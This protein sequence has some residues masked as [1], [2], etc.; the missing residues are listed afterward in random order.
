M[1]GEFAHLVAPIRVGERDVK[2]RMF[3]SPM[4]RNYA[5]RDGSPS[6][7]TV[8]HYAS[9]ASGGVGWLDVEATFIEAAGRARSHQLGLHD[10]RCVP[11]FARMAA[12]AHEHG[13]LIGVELVHAGRNTS[14]ALSGHQ[15]L[16]PSPV[17]CVEAGGDMPH[18]L[19]IDEIATVKD[20]YREAAMRAEAA[21]FDAIELHSAHG[22]LPFAF[23]SA[24]TNRRTDQY[25]GSLNS[26]MRFALEV[27]DTIRDSVAS[28]TIVG[29]R[30]SCDELIPGGF[31]LDQAV[32]YAKALER[33]GVDYLNVSVGVY[34]SGGLIVPPMA[35]SPGWTLP[36]VTEIKRAVGVPVVGAG[37]FIDP[38]LAEQAIAEQR[39]DIVAMGRALLTDPDLPR[40]VL[41]GDAE[42]IV[43][44]IGCNQG[45]NTRLD[46]QEDV[47]CLVN[48]AVGREQTFTI[49]RAARARA[50]AVVGGGPAGME[51]ARVAAER[52]HSVTLFERDAHLGGQAV[53]AGMA[54]H[55][56]GWSLLV[57]DAG[58]RL[59]SR[60]VDVRLGAEP[61]VEQLLTA[62]AVVLAT[63]A[64]FRVPPLPGANGDLAKDPLTVMTAPAQPIR[65]AIVVKDRGQIALSVVALL[66][67][68]GAEVHLV[69][70]EQ[71]LVDPPADLGC[72]ERLRAT[73]RLRVHVD[74]DV[75]RVDDRDVVLTK[76]GA[77][78]DLFAERIGAPD[79]IVYCDDRRPRNEL[80]HDLRRH[81]SGVEMHEIGDCEKPL[82]ALEAVYAGAAIGRTL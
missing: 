80:A 4:E 48:P 73:E 76:S 79:V 77:I 42:E 8:A 56:D 66:L 72:L 44:C 50:V 6:D 24:R 54:P 14:T 36:R 38:H 9:I 19:T 21:G 3:L 65:R 51:A 60:N 74:R 12:A 45:C 75:A 34:E 33:H 39:I 23:L 57:A 71:A 29:C 37:R 59:R 26:R 68:R 70:S 11:G 62:D 52:G 64:G 27:V 18:A 47:T 55:R 69:T 49:R 43:H 53:L 10:D 78:G 28:S 63:G 46:R 20:R 15:V 2:N 61:T 13:A 41:E 30:F 7:R 82:T 1:A 17:P 31:D 5:N 32:E 81:D 35:V 58:R 67:E 16:G 25:G 40:K 22:Y